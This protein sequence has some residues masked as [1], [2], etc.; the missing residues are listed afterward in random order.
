MGTTIKYLLGATGIGVRHDQ[1]PAAH[2]ERRR[3]QR[4]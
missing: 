1:V 3:G 2:I 4:P